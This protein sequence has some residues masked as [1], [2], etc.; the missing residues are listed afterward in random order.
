MRIL[1]TVRSRPGRA[2]HT[3]SRWGSWRACGRACGVCACGHS[4]CSLEE[5]LTFDRVELPDEAAR[6]RAAAA[7]LCQA[8]RLTDPSRRRVRR[9]RASAICARGRFFTRPRPSRSGTRAAKAAGTSSTPG[10]T[11]AG[12]DILVFS[13]ERLPELRARQPDRE[14]VMPYEYV[15]VRRKTPLYKRMP[16]ADELY[17][18][19]EEPP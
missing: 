17:T 12:R 8:L 2:A 19:P 6:P 5:P 18:V 4:G 13:G 9:A 7:G 3:T 15:T 11:S 1:M 14:A 10:A 16:K